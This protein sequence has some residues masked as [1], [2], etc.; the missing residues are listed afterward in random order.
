MKL[1]VLGATALLSLCLGAAS[2]AAEADGV[3][4]NVIRLGMVNAQ[5]GP[6]AALGQSMLAG[7]Q[8]V[9]ADLNARGGVHGRRIEL[10]VADDSY[11]PEQTVEHTLRLVQQDKVLALFGYVGTPT[12]NAVVPLL[13]ELQVP[14]VAV[15]SGA[16]SLRRPQLPLLFNVRA[17]YDEEAQRLVAHLL[18]KG[19]NKVAVVYQ[20]DGFGVAVLTSVNKALKGGAAKLH[21]SATFQRNTVAIKMALA[22]MVE[23]E[24]DAIVVVGPY[25]PVAAFINQ[26]RAKGL[27]SVFATVSFVGTESLLERLSDGGQGV[28]VSQVMPHPAAED[29]AV[30]Q[31]CRELLQAHGGHKLSYVSL[32]GCISAKLMVEALQRAGSSPTRSSLLASLNGMSSLDLGGVVLQLSA[33]DHQASDVTYL[34]RLIGG[35]IE[36]VR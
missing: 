33:S 27:N 30:V 16:A 17:S 15:L 34:T 26:A 6:A 24:P 36:D 2:H 4:A 31:H 18:D 5:S 8:A 35:R 11:E 23:A 1:N 28:L 22:T 3:S 9:F 12:T 21:A 25:T 19:L 13:T 7:A 20:N 14:L 32:E 29:M 10:R